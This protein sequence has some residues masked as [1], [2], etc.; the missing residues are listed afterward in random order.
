[1]DGCCCQQWWRRQQRPAPSTQLPPTLS[2]ETCVHSAHSHPLWGGR[3][4]EEPA[5]ESPPRRMVALC[6]HGSHVFLGVMR[7]WGQ[8]CGC[9]PR[10]SARTSARPHFDLLCPPPLSSVLVLSFFLHLLGTPKGRSPHRPALCPVTEL[11]APLWL[12]L[13]LDW[14]I[15]CWRKSDLEKPDNLPLL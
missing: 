2:G 15:R 12:T 6:E 5:E 7:F 13:L 3:A 10:R 8:D 9:L 1:M 4:V 14:R 11:P